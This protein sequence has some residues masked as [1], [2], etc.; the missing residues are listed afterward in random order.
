V[1]VSRG[2]KTVKRFKARTAAPNRTHRLRLPSRK[3]A[4][5]D[6]KVR[7]TVGRGAGRVVSTLV[8]RRL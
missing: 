4:K 1:T 6:Y 8:S 5:G 3:L 7:I 2:R